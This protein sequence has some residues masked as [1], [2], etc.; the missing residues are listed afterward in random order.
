MSSPEEVVYTVED[1][2]KIIP[3]RYPFLLIDRVIS[4]NNGQDPNSRAGR[5][6]IAV[7]NVTFNEP[8]FNGHFPHR[9]VMPGVLQVEAMAQAGAIAAYR[10]SD[11]SQDVAIASIKNSRF[12][13]P[14]VPGDSLRIHA[15][16]VKDRGSM[17][18]MS[19]AI[20]VDGAKAAE[21]EILAKVF[22]R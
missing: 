2:M 3:H 20:F 13:R 8:F 19:A 9:P 11:N 4:L 15:E 22:A 12:R 18:G 14:I 17:L 16:V 21:A 7:K 10:Q 5:K 6:V 1:I